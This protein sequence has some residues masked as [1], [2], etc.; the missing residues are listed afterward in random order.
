LKL[1]FRHDLVPDYMRQ[2]SQTFFERNGL[3]FA[4]GLACEN[5]IAVI[6]VMFQGRYVACDPE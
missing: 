5:G 3:C 1:H 6:K 4:L 2:H